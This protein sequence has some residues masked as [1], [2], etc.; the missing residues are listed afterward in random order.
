MAA[1][2]LH[3]RAYGFDKVAT[4]HS[5][6]RGFS[7]DVINP[8]KGHILCDRSPVICGFGL[9]IQCAS[10]IT[11]STINNP[12]EM[13]IAFTEATFRRE[14]CTKRDEQTPHSQRSLR[15]D[16]FRW[17]GLGQKI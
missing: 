3:R 7:R 6:Q 8:Q 15:R 12:K 14:S 10:R 4:P 2:L 5:K 1:L 9:R 11:K 13:L 16:N 17:T